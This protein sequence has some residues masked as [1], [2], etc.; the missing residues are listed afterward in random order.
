MGAIFLAGT[1]PLQQTFILCFLQ[2]ASITIFLGGMYHL[3]QQ[4]RECLI[5]HVSSITIFL[6]GMYHL[7]TTT[8]QC[9]CKQMLSIWIIFLVGIY[10]LCEWNLEGKVVGNMFTN[11]LCTNVEC[12]DCPP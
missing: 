7:L 2:R 3:L 4:C 11:S 8:M 6:A 12:V 1:C 10:H 5:Q 9:F